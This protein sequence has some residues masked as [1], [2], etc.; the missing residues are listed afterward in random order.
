[1][2]FDDD[3]FQEILNKK[4]EFEQFSF[5]EQASQSA[6]SSEML[7]NEFSFDEVSDAVNQNK[8]HKAYLKIPN[9][10]MKNENAKI[11]LH[12]F[13]NLCFKSGLNPTDWDFSDI[14]PIQ[15]RTKIPANR[16]RTVAFE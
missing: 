5:Q 4:D 9:E 12:K 7:N 3:F 16:S 13:F 2:A 8:L 1:M 11:L 10:A 14:K 6:Y 15:K